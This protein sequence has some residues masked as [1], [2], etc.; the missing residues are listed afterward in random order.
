VLFEHGS[1]FIRIGAVA[2]VCRAAAGRQA[3]FRDWFASKTTDAARTA[4]PSRRR[5]EIRGPLN[6]EGPLPRHRADPDHVVRV[7]HRAQIDAWWCF[8]LAAELYGDAGYPRAADSIG[9]A[10][11]RRLA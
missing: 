5:T 1:G 8:D 9:G 7:E 10:R 2:W 6:G 3:E 4:P 11:N